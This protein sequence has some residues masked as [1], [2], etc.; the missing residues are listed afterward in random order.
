MDDKIAELAQA[1]GLKVGELY[2]S[3]QKAGR[4]KEIE[5]SITEDR[6][7]AWLLERNTVV[8]DAK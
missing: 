1:R 5:R 7:F 6:V 2:A 4:L 3:L 8:S